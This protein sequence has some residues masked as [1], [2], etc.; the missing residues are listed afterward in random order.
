MLSS[1]NVRIGV[2]IPDKLLQAA[3][4]LA[5]KFGGTVV[6]DPD[7]IVEEAWGKLWSAAADD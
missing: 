1:G 5:V 3:E 4:S 6:D 2:K 7:G